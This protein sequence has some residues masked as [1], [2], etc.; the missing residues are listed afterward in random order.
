MTATALEKDSLGG[1]GLESGET[2]HCRNLNTIKE[3]LGLLLQPS[4]EHCL[5]PA[6]TIANKHEGPVWS[7]TG[8]RS[9]ITVTCLSPPRG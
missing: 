4:F 9:M 1:G 6:G 3:C 8:L 7:R 2:V 5:R